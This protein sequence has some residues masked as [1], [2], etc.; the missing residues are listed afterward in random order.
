MLARLH[1]LY[2]ETAHAGIVAERILFKQDCPLFSPGSFA[3]RPRP[4]TPASRVWCLA[5]DGD[6]HRPAGSLDG[7]GRH[8]RVVG[9]QPSAGGLGRQR[10]HLYTVPVQ[11][12]SPVLRRLAEKGA[13]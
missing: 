13:R 9:C 5:G 1:Q 11:G 8:H 6:S 3:E 2:P 4:S 10:A 12:R 7:T